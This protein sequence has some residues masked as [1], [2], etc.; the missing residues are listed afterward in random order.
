MWLRGVA[1]TGYWVQMVQQVP[2]REGVG[3]L[4]QLAVIA[5]L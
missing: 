3:V 4:V 2:V 5:H 1:T